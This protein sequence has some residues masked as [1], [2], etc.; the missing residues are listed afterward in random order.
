MSAA[1]LEPVET[2]VLSPEA[3]EGACTR[4]HAEIRDDRGFAGLC[5][6]C[7]TDACAECLATLGGDEGVDDGRCHACVDAVA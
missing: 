5:G 1:L 2:V 7:L 3:P 4:C 6:G